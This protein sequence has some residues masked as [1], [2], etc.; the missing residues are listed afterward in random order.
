MDVFTINFHH[1]GKFKHIGATWFY[2]GGSICYLD[3]F[4]LDTF[5]YFD[6]ERNVKSIYARIRRIA[7]LKP[8]LSFNEGSTFF[9]DDHGCW[10]ILKRVRESEID[11]YCECLKEKGNDNVNE[12][13]KSEDVNAEMDVECSAVGEGYDEEDEESLKPEGESLNE[14]EDNEG[15]G[16]A[17]SNTD[18]G[19]ASNNDS[20]N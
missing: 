6:L 4:S 2:V 9:N 8:G 14:R 18:E 17:P 3:V 7:Y 19:N 15:L 10:D 5:S 20:A 13:V 12:M 11:V 1:G 16:Q